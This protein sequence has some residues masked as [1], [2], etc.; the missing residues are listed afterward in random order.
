MPRSLL[1]SLLLACACGV[2]LGQVPGPKLF[3]RLT[4]NQ[5][6]I[7]FSY[8]GDIWIIERAG[9]DARRITNHPGE[10]NFPMFSP[11]GSQLTF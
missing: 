1:L 7:A 5:T 6:H 9:G 8:A 3:S 10:E 2:G 4:V 11:D